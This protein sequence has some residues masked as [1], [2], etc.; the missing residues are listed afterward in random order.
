MA[1]RQRVVAEGEITHV[2]LDQ[3]W[4]VIEPVEQFLEYLRQEKYSPHTVRSY[5]GGLAV[6]W[7]LLEARDQD[8]RHVGVDDLARFVRRLRNRGTDP[9]VIALRPDKAVPASTVDAALTAVMSFYRYHAI[10]SGVPAA[11]SFYVHVK[12]GT[13]EARGQYASFLAHIDGGRDRRVVGR[14]RGPHTP[15]PFLTPRQI[16][17]IKDDA[18]RLDDGIWAGDVRFRLL[19][20]LLEETGLRIAEALLLR[21]RDWKPGTGTTAL[22]EVQPREDQRRRLRVKNQQYRRL[23]ISD[24]LDNL[25]GEHL[26]QLAEHGVEFADD[27]TVFINLYRGEVGQPLRPETVYDWIDGFKRRHPL[28]PA[29]W[30]P[31]WFR[32]T[33]ATALLLADVPPH[34][35][36][37]RL[38]HQDINTLM[39]TYAHVTDDAAM[40]AAADWKKL[41]AR[42]GAGA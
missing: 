29:R 40:R 38:G 30:T 3:Q 32:H 10:V 16:T 42:W 2:V 25:Y 9:T 11:R 4:R 14:R 22:I 27:D 6:W 39:T 36:Q 31:H 19:W 7:T 17:V 21:H 26:F 12:G 15:P 33:H 5:A 23:Y 41:V 1:V 20:T 24:E 37:R 13:M 28:L 8:W 34:V 18:A 35:V